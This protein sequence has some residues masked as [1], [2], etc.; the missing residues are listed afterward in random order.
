MSDDKKLDPPQDG[1]VMPPTLSR[2]SLHKLMVR[3]NEHQERHV[4]DYVERQAGEKVLHAEKVATERINGDDHEVWDVH[5]DK[6]RWWVVI[7]PTSLY[8]QDAIPSLDFVL[9]FHVGFIAR[10]ASRS[11]GYEKGTDAERELVI[12]T[13]RRIEQARQALKAADEVEEFQAVGMRCRECLLTFVR[14]LVAT[15][16]LPVSNDPPKAADFPAWTDLIANTI[17]PGPSFEYVRGYLKATGERAWR[18]VNWLTHASNATKNDAELA[19]DAT[20]HVT[21]NYTRVALEMKAQAPEQCNRCKSHQIVVAWRPDFG[22]AGLYM[23]RCEGCG[24]EWSP[25]E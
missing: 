4:K 21:L 13:S 22:E 8:P 11:S 17:A 10:M 20:S 2:E 9:S 15:I 18:L 23:A 24:A 16:D 25:D 5:T 1:A 3:R 19:W 14:E 7:P 12:V 6:Q